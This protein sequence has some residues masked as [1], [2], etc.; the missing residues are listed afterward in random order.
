MAGVRSE[1][2]TQAGQLEFGG[3]GR[4]GHPIWWWY[5]RCS[6]LGTVLCNVSTDSSGHHEDQVRSRVWKQ[7]AQCLAPVRTQRALSSSVLVSVGYRR[8]ISSLHVGRLQQENQVHTLKEMTPDQKDGHGPGLPRPVT[9]PTATCSSTVIAGLCLRTCVPNQVIVY[10]RSLPW[11]C[12]F[13]VCSEYS[14]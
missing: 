5:S 13:S 14:L 8:G 3:R 10:E 2:W 1:V 9:V 6:I 12:L 11:S 7:A 4:R